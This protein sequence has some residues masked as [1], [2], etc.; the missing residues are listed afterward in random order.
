M[1]RDEVNF[2]ALQTYRVKEWSEKQLDKSLRLDYELDKDAVVL[3]LG[4][5]KGDWAYEISARYDC[6]IYIF[7]PIPSFAISIRRRFR[8]IKKY[9]SITTDLVGKM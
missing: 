7:E 9:L 1:N 6:A 4:G 8:A 5:Y 3:D 2:E